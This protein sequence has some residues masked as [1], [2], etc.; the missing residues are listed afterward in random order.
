LKELGKK[1]E[2]EILSKISSFE[3]YSSSI[4]HFSNFYSLYKLILDNTYYTFSDQSHSEDFGIKIDLLNSIK[5]QCKN[6]DKKNPMTLTKAFN[7][8]EKSYKNIQTIKKSNTI[9][10]ILP[11][12]IGE[13]IKKSLKNEKNDILIRKGFTFVSKTY[14]LIT[15]ELLKG[16]EELQNNSKLNNS[17][18]SNTF[19]IDTIILGENSFKKLV[20][21]LNYDILLK[22]K[23]NEPVKNPDALEFSASQEEYWTLDIEKDNQVK[24]II[25]LEET[26]NIVGKIV[27]VKIGDDKVEFTVN[28]LEELK[29]KIKKKESILDNIDINLYRTENNIN[30]GDFESIKGKDEMTFK[31]KPDILGKK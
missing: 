20:G 11:L 21:V 22:L 28:S 18:K 3:E 13:D 29:T 5:G 27:Y 1:K 30:I 24:S 4:L 10:L 25:I 15:K 17:K 14:Q 23:V 31:I 7:E 12:Y 19:P 9:F 26:K 8:C 16:M 6:E 2:K